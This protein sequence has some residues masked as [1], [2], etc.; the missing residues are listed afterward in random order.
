MGRDEELTVEQLDSKN[1]VPLV[2]DL[3][4]DLGDKYDEFP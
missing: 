2:E 1:W 3:D 4:E